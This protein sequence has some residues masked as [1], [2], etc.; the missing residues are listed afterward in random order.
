M[1]QS[2]VVGEGI[3]QVKSVCESWQKRLVINN[4]L[5]DAFCLYFH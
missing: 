3:K 1:L 4:V 5:T 2:T